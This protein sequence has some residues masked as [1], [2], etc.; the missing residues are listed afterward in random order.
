MSEPD[1]RAPPIKPMELRARFRQK[2]YSGLE[3]LAIETLLN[4]FE[5]I[6]RNRGALH[7]SAKLQQVR[8]RA[9]GVRAI[10]VEDD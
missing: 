8:S 1:F 7:G 6:V 2:P 9:L 4:L 5:L 10:L 3:L